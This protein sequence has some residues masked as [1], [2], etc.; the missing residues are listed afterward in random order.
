MG[1]EKG[2][3]EWLIAWFLFSRWWF[4][5]SAFP[6]LAGTLGPVASAF[7]ICA[8]VR[9]WRQMVKGYTLGEEPAPPFIDDPP[10]YV[11]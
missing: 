7:S 3:A 5:S 4:A 6:M 11:L 1:T 9:P 10:W 2:A 8:L